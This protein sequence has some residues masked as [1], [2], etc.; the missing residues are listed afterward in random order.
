MLD[1]VLAGRTRFRSLL[2]IN[3]SSTIVPTLFHLGLGYF[4]DDI[5]LHIFISHEVSLQP[6]RLCSPL[7]GSRSTFWTTKSLPIPIWSAAERSLPWR[8][9]KH[10]HWQWS[11][12]KQEDFPTILRSRDT[13]SRDTTSWPTRQA[14][15]PRRF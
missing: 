4:L 3:L 10:I 15:A 7:L 11:V 14:S 1:L 12:H 6:D 8:K 2:S 13:G 5:L 9:G